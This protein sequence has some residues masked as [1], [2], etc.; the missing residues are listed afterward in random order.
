[1]PRTMPNANARPTKPQRLTAVQRKSLRSNPIQPSLLILNFHQKMNGLKCH[2]WNTLITLRSSITKPS[3]SLAKVTK[4]MAPE[5]PMDP[6]SPTIMILLLKLPA[7]MMPQL[8]AH[9][10]LPLVQCCAAYSLSTKLARL[11]QR[12]LDWHLVPTLP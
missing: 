8:Q 11:E 1:M 7:V 4:S 5:L 12:R 9:Q 3:P 6:K 2:R 10:I